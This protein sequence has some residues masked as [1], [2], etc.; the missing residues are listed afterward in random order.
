MLQAIGAVDEKEERAEEHCPEFVPTEMKEREEEEMSSP[1]AKIPVTIITGYLGARKTILLNYILT[2]QHSKRGAVILNKFGEGNTVEKSLDVSQSGALYQERLK[3]INVCLCCSV[4]DSGLGANENLMQKKGK[5][6]DI[7]LDTSGLADPG[8]VASL[9]WV[10]AELGIDIYL[11]G[12]ITLMD[13][14]YGLKHLAEEK[15]VGLIHEASRQAALADI[16]II[17]K[18][19]WVSQ[20]DLSKLRTTIRS[21]NDWENF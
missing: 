15:P 14:K 12:I 18:T 6:D 16:I 4:K 19:D 1:S 3:L 20:E 9:F 8:A 11:A 21:I 17:N 10:D 2:E 7:P 13:S 5:F